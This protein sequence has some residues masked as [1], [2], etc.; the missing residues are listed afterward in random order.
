MAKKIILSLVLGFCLA[1]GVFA[2]WWNSYVPP[3]ES[4]NVL[5]QAGVGF[6]AKPADRR[7]LFWL[8]LSLKDW[9]MKYNYG[10][11]PISLSGDFKLPVG[12]PITVGVQASFNTFTGQLRLEDWPA[13]DRNLDVLNMS[14][15]LRP[16]YHFN[17]GKGDGGFMD[18]L[19]TYAGV[20]LGWIISIQ[21]WDKDDPVFVNTPLSTYT[22][23]VSGFMFGAFA[24][25]RYFFNN[26]L[27]LYLEAG[28]D[29]VQFVGLGLT[30]KF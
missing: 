19:D 29:P 12:L 11:P 6:G 24:G 21:N 26:A 5:L 3:M 18:R 23:D 1:G 22:T 7:G 20:K 13:G 2:D 28:W 15:A 9:T 25:A 30:V 10:I 27:A 4:G 8:G 14:F 17:F 16:A